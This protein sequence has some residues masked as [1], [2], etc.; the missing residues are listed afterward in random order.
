VLRTVSV[1]V[2]ELATVKPT[3]VHVLL[4]LL[5]FADSDGRCWPSLR[6]LAEVCGMH[7]SRV[8]RAVAE[9]ESAGILTRAR[10]G[11]GTLYRLAERFL[12]K[13]LAGGTVSRA[14]ETEG[15]PRK[16]L[17]EDFK[18]EDDPVRLAPPSAAPPIE[19]PQKRPGRPAEGPNPFARRQWLRRLNSFISE[20]LHGPQQWSG[21]EVVAK[22]EAGLLDAS[23]QRLLDG[24]DRMMRLSHSGDSG[25]SAEGLVKSSRVS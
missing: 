18:R 14:A 5:S 2:A 15:L 21:W 8:Q 23:E 7:L 3:H 10:R 12:W 16:D 22:A 4:G 6:K 13:R 20:R 9:M 11:A 24:L 17:G 1:P 19:P 25:K